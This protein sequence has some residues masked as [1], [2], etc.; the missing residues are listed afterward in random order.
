MSS[1][2]NGKTMTPRIMKLRDEFFA[3][4]FGMDLSRAYAITRSYKE[5]EGQPMVLRRAKAFYETLKTMPLYIREDELLVGSRS[6]ELGKR[7][8]YPDYSLDRT[9]PWPEEISSYWKYRSADYFSHQMHSDAVKMNEKEMSGGITTGTSTGY[10]HLIVDYEKALHLGL[11]GIISETKAELEK[12]DTEAAA[13]GEPG[14]DKAAAR[15]IDAEKERL[16]NEADFLNS[17]VIAGEAVI[18]WANRYADLAEKQAEELTEKMVGAAA[19]DQPAMATR[20]EELL[21]IAATCR[22]VPEY[23][24]ENFH[25]AM[26]SFLLVHVAI[27]IEQYGW[28]V[29]TGRFDQYMY[30]YYKKDLED[31]TLTEDEAWELVLSL[32]MKLMENI[33]DGIGATHF[34]N[35]TIG[36]TD[37][38]GND[39][40]NAFT[41]VI[42][43]AT[44]ATRFIQPALS[45]RWHKNM[46]PDV[47]AHAMDVIG[48]GMGMPAL[49]ND[50]IITTALQKNG[51][52][53]DDAYNYGIVGCVEP[54]IPGRE[55]A[56]TS[57]G[58]LN[59][60][61]VIE[62]TLF[63][64]RSNQTGKQIS[65]QTGD[66]ASFKTFD[67]FFDAYSRQMRYIAG[68]NIQTAEVAATAQKLVVPCPFTSMLLDDCIALHKEKTD[69]GTRYSL[70]GVCIIGA[71]NAVDCMLNL[72]KLVFEQKRF[73]MQEVL[74]A[75]ST[76]FENNEIM[77]Q[78]MLHQPIRY[79]NDIPEAD[80][81]ANKIYAVHSDFNRMHADFRNGHYT[82]G[83]W[84]V[85]SH[86]SYG[87][88]TGA[89]PDGRKDGMP[90]VD[91]VGAVQGADTHGPTALL[92]SVSTLN[93]V[94]Q[95]A[96]G[97]TCNIK[98][99][100]SSIKTA[101][102][103]RNV[104]IMS[105]TFMRLGGQ[106]L[107]INVVDNATLLDAQQHPENY[108]DLVVRVAGFSAYFTR[109]S[110]VVQDEVI[111][112]N[113]QAAG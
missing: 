36:G 15:R 30:P 73:T 12:I 113:E 26:Q 96:G 94:D 16:K 67:E 97:N 104:G 66:A 75:L 39:A 43:D 5:T 111:S 18:L 109:L 64:G 85:T 56:M 83:I 34:Q 79:G 61:K 27:H 44:A 59:L 46:D 42:L 87:E 55:E 82:D 13:L 50:E 17:V 45:L 31:G 48:Q 3:Q 93:N 25:E 24:A 38:E 91:G 19:E 88:H 14:T 10:G 2:R 23:P 32:W 58:H 100:A 1:T 37:S 54:A 6:S 22:R 57:G 4:E 72:K 89:T 53:R 29:S 86:V 49:F 60:A 95:W 90:L 40:S 92:R 9:F 21:T 77:R 52:A 108:Q 41:H 70:P 110:K 98:F 99:S 28:A 20:K 47:W 63:N 76:N 81:M 51:V 65:I 71:T 35:M 105:D 112:R 80:E 8:S 11:R 78:I 107:Q 62:L 101:N 84:P 74:D 106:E 7:T 33:H 68:L 103:L 102:A 69:S